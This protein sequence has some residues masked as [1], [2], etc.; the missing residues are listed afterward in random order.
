M[1]FAGVVGTVILIAVLFVSLRWT[2]AILIGWLFFFIA[3]LPTMQIIGFSNVIASDKFAYVP[4]IGLLMAFTAFL[5]WLFQIRS[6]K[7]A[8][9]VSFAAIIIA[10]IAVAEARATRDYL[11]YWRDSASLYKH[12]LK[13]APNAESLHYNLALAFDAEGSYEDAIKEYN[14]AIVLDPNSYGSYNNLGLLYASQGNNEK[15]VEHYKKAI[16]I[17][18]DYATA[19]CNLGTIYLDQDQLE[20][21]MQMFQLAL[22]FKPRFAPAHYN[23]ANLRLKTGDIDSAIGEYIETTK[24]DPRYSPAF[25]NLG[26][27]FQR[28]HKMD[29]ALGYYRK[30]LALGPE[31]PMYLNRVAWL[32]AARIPPNNRDS[33]EA[34]MLTQKAAQLTEF[35]NP[36]IL[37]TLAA[38]YA[39]QQNFQ[40]AVQIAETAL[41]QARDYNNVNLINQIQ[42][43]INLYKQ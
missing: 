24:Y 41:K 34:I 19:Y 13:F 9:Y 23:I 39:S 33:D 29:E 36:S 30:A 10:C 31:N 1:V 2:R 43:Q 40:M 17:K 5:C 27:L 22:K 4:S 7:R 25:Y 20:K 35:K 11:K 12:M 3:I 38:A 14:Q 26:I 8:A 21:A 6:G 18:P 42:E 15:A 28:Q 32:L 37:A 16:E